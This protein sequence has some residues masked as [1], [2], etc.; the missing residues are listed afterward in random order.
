MTLQQLKYVIE[1][2]NRGSINEAAKRLFISQPSLSNAIRELEEEMQIYD[3]RAH[4]K[5]ITLSKERGG[6]SRLCPAGGRAGGAAGEPLPERQASPAAFFG[7]DPALRV[8][9]QRLRQPGAGTRAGGIRA[10][11]AGDEDVRDYRGCESVRS[12]IGILYLNEFNGKVIKK[13][14]S[15]RPAVHE[16]VH[17]GAAYLHQRA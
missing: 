5:G 8:R 14:L 1:V 11:A 4:N 17:G 6:I 12:E 10:G 7:I 16:P 13:L 2:A 9:G 3:F 15:R